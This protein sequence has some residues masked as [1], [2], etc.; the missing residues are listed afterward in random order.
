MRPSRIWHIANKEL[1]FNIQPN[2]P[3]VGKDFNVTRGGD[4][5]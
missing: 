4:S 3:L 5:R 2:Y 1:G